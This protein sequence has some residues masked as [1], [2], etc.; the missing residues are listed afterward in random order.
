MKVKRA[1]VFSLA[2][3]EQEF[4]VGGSNT[5]NFFLANKE[6]NL[7]KNNNNNAKDI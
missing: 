1:L 7:I 3:A 6:H 2:G 5:R 4:K